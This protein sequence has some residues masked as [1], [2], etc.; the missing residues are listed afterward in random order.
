MEGESMNN[1]FTP[2]QPFTTQ[3]VDKRGAVWQFAYWGS[4]NVYIR[5]MFDDENRAISTG[6][7]ATRDGW[8]YLIDLNYYGMK[9]DDVT[10]EWLTL[11]ARE[12]IIERDTDIL[13]GNVD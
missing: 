10:T 4:G 7:R 3:Q 2:E 11:R 8:P 1:N 13:T 5:E 12:W 9:P 6:N